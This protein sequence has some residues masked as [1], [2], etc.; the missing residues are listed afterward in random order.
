MPV[1]PASLVLT[2]AMV[3]WRDF[4]KSSKYLALPRGYDER[5]QK[6]R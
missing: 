3:I 4:H 5:P 1:Q 6:H 2:Q